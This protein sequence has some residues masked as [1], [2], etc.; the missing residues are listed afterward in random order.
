M[1]TPKERQT[2]GKFPHMHGM[3]S[4][5]D[6]WCRRLAQFLIYFSLAQLVALTMFN[7][8]S[9]NAC[10]SM[11]LARW[12]GGFSKQQ[13]NAKKTKERQGLKSNGS[14][15]SKCRRFSLHCH[16]RNNNVHLE[17]T[18]IWK[19]FCFK[20]P[21]V[22]LFNAAVKHYVFKAFRGVNMLTA[23]VFSMGISVS[24]VYD[25]WSFSAT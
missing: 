3:H 1:L 11:I 23:C 13:W 14:S 9:I 25:F 4:M 24:R 8:Q 21:S 19:S 6:R 20:F 2:D 5:G 7:D 17:P 12:D 16:R 10:A 18:H 22:R 15:L